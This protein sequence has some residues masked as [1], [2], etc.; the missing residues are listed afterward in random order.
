M[1]ILICLVVGPDGRIYVF[2][3]V[4]HDT[5]LTAESPAYIAMRTSSDDGVHF[6]PVHRITGRFNSIPRMAVPG[7]LRNLTGPTAVSASQGVLYV[8]WAQVWRRHTDGAVDANIEISRSTNSGRSWS[9]PQSVNDVAGGDRF[10]PSL[11]ILHDGSVGVAFYD[12]RRSVWQLDTYAARVSFSRG[13]HR[14]QNVR[15]NLA[16]APIADIYYI[17]P[18]STC[19]SP[20]RF[21]GDYIGTAGTADNR[22]CVVWADTGLHV[23][24]ETDVWFARVTLPS[25]PTGALLR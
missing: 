8:A 13:F 18:G 25:V 15:V 10:M 2:W 9:L 24:D 4:F 12:R 20:G 14:S 1:K 3:S 23:P 21:F 16:S 7:S 5:A 11:S 6:G 17:A 22:L 19:F